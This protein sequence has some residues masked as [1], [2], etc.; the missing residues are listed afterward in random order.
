MKLLFDEN[1]SR[2]LCQKLEDIFPDCKQVCLVGLENVDDRDIWQYAAKEGLTIVSKDGDFHDL[3][4]CLAHLQKSSGC[5]LAIAQRTLPKPSFAAIL[6]PSRALKTAM[7]L[8]FWS[9]KPKFIP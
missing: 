1:L 3:S 5:K 2:R 6:R 7:K 4:F 9:W 8:Q